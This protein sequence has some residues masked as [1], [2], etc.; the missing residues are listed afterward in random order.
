AL[1]VL[2]SGR[3]I[4]F[5]QKLEAVDRVGGFKR[6][7]GRNLS[8]RI[9]K[10]PAVLISNRIDHCHADRLLQSFE[11]PNNY[12]PTGPRAGQR[13]VKMI[14]PRLGSVG[15]RA[16]IRDPLMKRIG[17]PLE[18]AGFSLLVWKLRFHVITNVHE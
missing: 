7:A 13:N 12:R 2:W 15:C 3:S 16:I 1:V 4:G 14:A 5:A 17:L 18:F 10:G 6:R 11:L 9:A 8:R